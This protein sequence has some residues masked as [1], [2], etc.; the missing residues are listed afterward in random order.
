MFSFH[1]LVSLVPFQHLTRT[2]MCSNHIYLLSIHK[3]KHKHNSENAI[4]KTFAIEIQISRAKQYLSNHEWLS[5]VCEFNNVGSA[6]RFFQT[7]CF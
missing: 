4:D 3:K 1:I 2:Q 7:R 5:C 6:V